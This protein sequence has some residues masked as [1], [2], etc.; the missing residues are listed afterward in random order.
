MRQVIS[1]NQDFYNGVGV[2]LTIGVFVASIIL[3]RGRG[4]PIFIKPDG[5]G[6]IYE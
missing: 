4:T 3:T 6:V 1:E 5:M 2:G